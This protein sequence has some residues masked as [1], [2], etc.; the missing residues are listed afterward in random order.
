VFVS[1]LTIKGIQTNALRYAQVE[2]MNKD[3]EGRGFLDTDQLIEVR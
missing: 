2:F 3:S 1:P